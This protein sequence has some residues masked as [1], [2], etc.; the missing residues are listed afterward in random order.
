MNVPMRVAVIGSPDRKMERLVAALSPAFQ[1]RLFRDWSALDSSFDAEAL[2][3]LPGVAH[4][5]PPTLGVP[6]LTLRASDLWS[7]EELEARIHGAKVSVPQPQ[8]RL[9]G[10][11]PAM[12]RV[13]GALV[14]TA[15]TPLPILLTGENG[16]GKDLAATVAH[17]LSTRAGQPFVAVNCGAVPAALAETEFFGCVRGA[18]TGAETRTGF[19]HQALGG[20]LFLDEVGEMPPEIQSKLLRVLENH[21]L[22][23]VGSSRLESTDFRLI[24]ATNRD[25]AAEVRAGRFREDLYYRIN[26]L[27]LRMPPLRERTE[28]LPLLI[29]HFLRSEAL[30][31]DRRVRVGPRGLEKLS[32][33]HWPGNL[34]QLR[35]V[36]LRAAVLNGGPELG[37]EALEWDS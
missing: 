21:E 12:A 7:V 34:R 30:G 1:P 8:S 13:R 5:P 3:V 14:T 22:R 36:L 9:L 27:S 19:C 32:A 20:T 11:S 17:E 16:T 18:F 35:N 33:Y 29:D 26:V 23:R 31:L 24:C 4:D 2:V 28:D 10:R 25:L 15:K 6:V 37:P